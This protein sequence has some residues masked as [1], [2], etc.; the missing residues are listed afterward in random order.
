MIRCKICLARQEVQPDVPYQKWQKKT[1]TYQSL[2]L[3]YFPRCTLISPSSRTR[4]LVT[5]HFKLPIF[6]S[7]QVPFL[8]FQSTLS[9]SSYSLKIP[10]IL[11]I[12]R[13]ICNIC[14]LANSLPHLSLWIIEN[15]NENAL[16]ALSAQLCW[17]NWAFHCRLLTLYYILSIFF[18]QTKFDNSK[19]FPKHFR[20]F[21]YFCTSI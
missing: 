4:H 20:F 10:S 3:R 13:P 8:T 5:K 2:S 17:N 16:I 18:L 11:L 21:I 12:M 15:R 7:R 1:F 19:S 6:S 14:S 9:F